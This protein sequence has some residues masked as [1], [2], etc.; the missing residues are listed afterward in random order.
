[1]STS[2]GNCISN[3]IYLA[4]NEDYAQGLVKLCERCALND[5]RV[6]LITKRKG[7][8][9]SSFSK[10]LKVLQVVDI[11]SAPCRLLDLQ[12][13]ISADIS[14]PNL[15]VF[16]LHSLILEAIQRPVMQQCST[17]QMVRHI[18]K[19]A[20][21]FVN[22]KEQVAATMKQRGQ[23]EALDTIVVMSQD[24]YP[25]TPAQFKLLI[26]LYFC[27]NECHTI[28]SKLAGRISVSQGCD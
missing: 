27:G 9:T 11:E 2:L 7:S 10:C 18:A 13:N 20:A 8:T 21:A 23:G 15:I 6:L 16:D 25:L 17:D 28:F 5:N 12:E 3:Y 22:Y 1:M 14:A 4:A 24:S 26:G 19:C